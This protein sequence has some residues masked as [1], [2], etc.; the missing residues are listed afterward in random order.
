MSD[1][2]AQLSASLEDYLEAI[3]NLNAAGDAVRVKDIADRMDVKMPSVTGALRSLASKGL[4]KH[5]PYE[6][7]ELTDDGLS[8]ARDIALRH[9]TVSEFLMSVLGLS[10]TDAEREACRLE[11]AI[12]PETL[13]KLIKFIE[14]VRACDADS[15]LHMEDFRN[16]LESP[17]GAESGVCVFGPKSAVARLSSACPGVRGRIVSVSGKGAIRKRLMEM[18]LTADARFEVI[19]VAP[20]GDPVE[21][22]V[23]G[24]YLSLRKSEADQIQVEVD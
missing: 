22:K 13:D 20:L 21:I 3:Y 14:F 5:E 4:V 1:P 23:R 15:S 7:V 10:E 12:Q 24:Y 9:S 17:K 19:R 16:Y 6:S 8:L 2:E 18:G 11:H